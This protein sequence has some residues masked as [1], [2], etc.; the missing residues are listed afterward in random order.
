MPSKNQNANQ[1]A[2][3]FEENEVNLDDLEQ[4]LQAELEA[5]FEDLDFIAEERE[6]ITIGGG[7]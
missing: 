5:Q 1:E 4:G 7:Y 2:I 6:H 3:D